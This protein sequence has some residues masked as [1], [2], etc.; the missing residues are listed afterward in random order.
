[1]KNKDNKKYFPKKEKFCPRAGSENFPCFKRRDLRGISLIEV[2]VGTAIMLVILTGLIASYHVAVKSALG[3]TSSVQ[4]VFLAEEGL[5]AVT[6]LRD[7]GW[8]SEIASLTS[9]ATYYLDWDGNRFVSTSTEEV[10]DGSFT[11]HF[12]V[13]D[14]YRDGSDDIAVSG[15]LDNGTKKI[16]VIVSWNEAS[17]VKT[18]SMTTYITNL[19][20]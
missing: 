6:S 4:A 12:I 8:D 20:E 7:I 2:V 17:E 10:I 11:R 3:T 14:V 13:E 1:M 18:K 9:G 15:T 19:F 5:E 16:T